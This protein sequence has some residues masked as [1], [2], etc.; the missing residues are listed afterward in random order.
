LYSEILEERHNL[1][2]LGMDVKIVLKKAIS[3][4]GRGGV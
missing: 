2:D 1:K 3:V 4:K